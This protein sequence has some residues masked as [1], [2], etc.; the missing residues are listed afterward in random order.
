MHLRS[1]LL[2]TARSGG[3]RES[4]AG[5]DSP[6]ESSRPECA[7][8][9]VPNGTGLYPIPTRT[10]V[11]RTEHHGYCSPMPRHRRVAQ[12][13]DLF[14]VEIS[15]TRAPPAPPSPVLL[16]SNLEASLAVLKDAEFD[17]LLRA[18]ERE[19]VRRGRRGL[20]P[21]NWEPL[22]R[23]K[24]PRQSGRTAAPTRGVTATQ[25]NL[26]RAALKAGVKPAAIARQFGLSQAL[27]RELMNTHAR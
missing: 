26:V 7:R 13:P 22:P 10:W 20:T 23:A 25:A 9:A 24:G 21:V 1:L 16:P 18:I 11:G 5:E 12:S 27:I 14:E 4:T 15:T 6:Q 8:Q 3:S 17:R 19:A 2:P